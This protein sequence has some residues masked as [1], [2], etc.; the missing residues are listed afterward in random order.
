MNKRSR[1]AARLHGRRFRRAIERGCL[2]EMQLLL[3]GLYLLAARA[4]AHEHEE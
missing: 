3:V 2:F 4:E 1:R